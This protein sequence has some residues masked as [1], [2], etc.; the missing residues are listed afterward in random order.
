MKKNISILCL[1]LIIISCICGC[2]YR[3]ESKEAKVQDENQGADMSKVEIFGVEPKTVEST[4]TVPVETEVPKT[5]T[6]PKVS[7][8]E[9]AVTAAP[10]QPE[11][12]ILYIGD[13]NKYFNIGDTINY[14]NPNDNFVRFTF[15]INSITN[16]TDSSTG[17]RSFK[18]NY[19]Y[20]QFFAGNN[21]LL[22]LKFFC[23]NKS[24]TI[25][26]N[27]NYKSGIYSKIFK[28][29]D[30]YNLEYNIGFDSIDGDFILVFYNTAINPS[31]P[32]MYKLNYNDI[33]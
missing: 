3:G 14:V 27:H 31:T 21:N 28:L 12:K 11:T 30:K 13:T 9:P 32:I 19:D 17:I 6:Q 5:T 22:N 1:L 20:T 8:P 2:G 15:K 26:Q 16:T 25:K 18:I 29:G 4:T 7:A 23:V 24:S 10:T 33:K